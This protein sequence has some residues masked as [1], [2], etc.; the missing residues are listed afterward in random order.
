[1]KKTLLMIAVLFLAISANAQ[2]EKQEET[3]K[4]ETV[5][6]LQ[7]N[8]VLLRKD[9]YDIGKVEGVIFQNIIITD[10]STGEKTGALRL[11]TSYYSSLGTDTY[12]GTLDFDELEGCIKSLTYIKDN[13]I[14]SLPET[15]TECEYKTKDENFL[16]TMRI[17]E[18][19]EKMRLLVEKTKQQYE[20]VKEAARECELYAK[21]VGKD[22]ILSKMSI[23]KL[24]KEQKEIE[25]YKDSMLFYKERDSLLW[26]RIDNRKYAKPVYLYKAYVKAVLKY[27]DGR[28][29][30]L[31]DTLHPV[32]NS[33]YKVYDW[34]NK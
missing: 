16:D 12:I 8:G 34:R 9:F 29:Q 21:V 23:D 20:K 13:V 28:T 24:E 3:S 22:D 31:A 11:E 10:I 25:S 6:L 17:N 27:N 4:S 32:M 14:T 7:K 2:S 26:L 18:N 19:N 1:M 30:N 15:Y 5:K 33:E